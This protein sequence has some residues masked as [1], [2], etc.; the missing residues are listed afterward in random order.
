MGWILFHALRLSVYIY[1]FSSDT[2]SHVIS[3]CGHSAAHGC[4]P[5]SASQRCLEGFAA[6][7]DAYRGKISGSILEFSR[8]GLSD[9]SWY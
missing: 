6:R 3:Q 5:V 7:P 9:S 4:C 1:V 2:P 8:S